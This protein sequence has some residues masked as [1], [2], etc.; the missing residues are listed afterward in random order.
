MTAN[1]CA[2]CVKPKDLP[3]AS[4]GAS[5]NDSEI[6]TS[7]KA[8]LRRKMTGY[9]RTQSSD[10]IH[11]WGVS[12]PRRE[13]IG[14]QLMHPATSLCVFDALNYFSRSIRVSRPVTLDKSMLDKFSVERLPW[15]LVAWEGDDWVGL[16]AFSFVRRTESNILWY[17][18]S[19]LRTNNCNHVRIRPSDP[20]L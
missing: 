9:S 13:D 12:C 19:Y 14:W 6:Q 16:S 7:Y 5:D 11:G 20:P 8:A 2:G 4:L 15:G 1:F 18:F 3:L 10:E 17:E